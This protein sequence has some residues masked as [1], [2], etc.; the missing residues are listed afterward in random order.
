[1]HP[2]TAF[3]FLYKQNPC[4]E[5][6][7]IGDLNPRRLVLARRDAVRTSHSDPVGKRERTSVWSHQ[8]ERVR[9]VTAV[10]C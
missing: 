6:T 5:K 10:V 4:P 7:G 9:T 8:P 3:S 1:M 2:I